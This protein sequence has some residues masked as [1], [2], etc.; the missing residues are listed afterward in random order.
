LLIDGTGRIGGVVDFELGYTRQ[1]I[2]D[3]A[4]EL[5]NWG[6]ASYVAEW[7]WE[8]LHLAEVFEEL[9]GVG[10]IGELLLPGEPPGE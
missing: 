1:E 6:V 8:A 7:D 5:Y 3:R 10:F 2:K 9:S 4:T